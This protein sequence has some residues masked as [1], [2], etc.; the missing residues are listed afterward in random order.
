M[1]NKKID[2]NILEELI[3]MIS[4]VTGKKAI[5]IDRMPFGHN[6]ITF[7]VTINDN[8]HLI[9]RTHSNPNTY[10]YTKHNITQLKNIG[11]PVPQILA[12]DQSKTKFSFTFMVMEK[13]PGE[14]LKYQLP[15]M[16]FQ[17]MTILAEQI[18]QIQRTVSTLH[19]GKGYG[20]VEIGGIGPYSNWFDF[21]VSECEHIEYNELSIFHS[22]WKSRISQQIILLEPYLRQIQPI[23]FLDDIT[24][25]NVIVENG[26]LQG[27][28]DFDC[29][30]Y[31]DSLYWLALTIVTIISDLSEREFWYTKELIRLLGL[32]L[33]QEKALKLYSANMAVQ[34]LHRLWLNESEIWRTR[35]IFSLDQWLSELE[36]NL[37]T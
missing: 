33:V 27:L 4:S 9:V 18:V 2:E 14:D 26:K 35:M 20:Y 31:G 29:V 30:C 5:K 37:F 19:H 13:I 34:F 21:F 11:L 8:S 23:C 17:Q 28:I 22:K 15:S 36:N 3:T 16:N 25:K 12:I 24:I 32:S 10:K 6:S 7:D 1:E